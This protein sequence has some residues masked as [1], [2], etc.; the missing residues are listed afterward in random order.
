MPNRNLH[1]TRDARLHAPPVSAVKNDHI[2]TT[3]MSTLRGPMRSPSQ[4]P[5][6]SNSAYAQPNAVNA[7][8]IWIFVSPSPSRIAGAACEMHTRSRYVM[9][10]SEIAKNSTTFRA[11]EGGGP[12]INGA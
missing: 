10:A 2:T 5:G 3:R 11:R 1:T 9:T 6:I 12:G 8:P 4:P 7:M